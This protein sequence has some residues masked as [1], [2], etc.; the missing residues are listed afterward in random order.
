MT[1]YL[2]FTLTAAIGAMGEHA[3]HERRGTLGW[4]GRSAILGL[5]GAAL[6][7]RRG[8][9]FSALD[10]LSMAVA[11]FDEGRVLRD[12]HTI[13]TVPTAAARNPQTRAEAL[14]RAG[15]RV[16]TTIT[17]RDY[18]CDPLFGVALW[19]GGLDTLHEAL[20]APTFNLWLGRKSCPLAA[21]LGARRVQTADYRAA[22]E[23]IRLPPWRA[24]AT[25]PLVAT[26]APEAVAARREQRH[27][28]PLDRIG[29]HFGPRMV[30]L[31]EVDI[32]PEPDA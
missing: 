18:R 30:S 21:P 14:A 24:G 25:A 9:D 19:G 13:Q 29:W 5:C 28:E 8:G 6:G 1:D 7:V 15:R 17:L 27:D 20:H 31:E 26:D 11:V 2:V 16:N 12:Y 22:L 3:G 32:R 23:Q 4:P 10:E